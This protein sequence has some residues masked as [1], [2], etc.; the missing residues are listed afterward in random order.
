MQKINLRLPALLLFILTSVLSTAAS[1]FMSYELPMLSNFTP[2][3]ALALFGGAY[4]ADKWKAVLN[5]VV[6]LFLTNIFINYLYVPK[7]VLW[8]SGLLPLYV[9]FIAMVFMGSLIKKVN[10]TSVLLASLAAV[11]LHWLITDIEPWL[12]S[13][14]YSKGIMGYFE[15]LTMALPFERNMLLADMVFGGILFGGFEWLKSRNKALQN[16]KELAV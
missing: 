7:L 13:A 16:R 15:S 8:T 14:L 11:A 10:V 3:S 6:V 5:I 1:R 2:M 4:F 9:S 12:D